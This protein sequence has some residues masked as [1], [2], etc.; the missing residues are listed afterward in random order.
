MGLTR[1]QRKERRRNIIQKG[2]ALSKAMFPEDK[3]ARREWL[4][5]LI[6]AQIDIPGLGEAAEKRLFLSLLDVI[7]DL[8]DGED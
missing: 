3:E 6:A 4:A 1:Q 5:T 2:I 7:V 8:V